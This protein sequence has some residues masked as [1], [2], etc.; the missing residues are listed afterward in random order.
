MSPGALLVAQSS[1]HLTEYRNSIMLGTSSIPRT[2]APA[3]GH[4]LLPL[5]LHCTI[6]QSHYAA[7][8]TCRYIE[9]ISRRNSN[10][11]HP[12][13][14]DAIRRNWRW[15][16]GCSTLSIAVGRSSS[17]D[18]SKRPVLEAGCRP[19]AHSAQFFIPILLGRA[20]HEAQ[21]ANG[22]RKVRECL[23]KTTSSATNL[24]PRV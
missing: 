13:P 14:P 4:T 11:T 15:G 24:S 8:P 5:P 10:N 2:S 22:A 6:H 7:G 3:L 19:M 9:S 23:R 20:T 18:V 12:L 1:H 17:L 21:Q 16:R